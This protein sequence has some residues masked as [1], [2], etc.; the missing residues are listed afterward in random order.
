MWK[1]SSIKC[2][3]WILGD[4]C[5]TRSCPHRLYAKASLFRCPGEPNTAVVCSFEG[6]YKL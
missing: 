4:N 3:T 1:V 6:K 5:I 2:H